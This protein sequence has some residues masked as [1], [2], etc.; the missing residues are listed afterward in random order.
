MS[1]CPGNQFW[2]QTNGCFFPT[3]SA[4]G[5]RREGS[6]W[7]DRQR[8][9]ALAR[10]CPDPQK[11]EEHTF[12]QERCLHSSPQLYVLPGN[13]CAFIFLIQHN[14]E[15]STFNLLK[16]NFLLG[17]TRPV[18]LAY[19]TNFPSSLSSPCHC[20]LISATPSLC[21]SW[22]GPA[23]SHLRAFAPPLPLHLPLFTWQLLLMLYIPAPRS[24]LDAPPLRHSLSGQLLIFFTALTTIRSSLFASVFTHLLSVPIECKIN[25]IRRL[26]WLVCHS[27]PSAWDSTWQITDIQ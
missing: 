8:Q 26:V 2:K 24:L 9:R 10:P 1:L 18:K 7:A 5:P 14:Y 22:M 13:L 12:H 15:T 25:E 17:P 3:S 19:L 11:K 27:I 23:I 16:W 21:I 6:R 4:W 20:A